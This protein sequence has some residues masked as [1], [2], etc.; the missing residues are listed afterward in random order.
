MHDD[1]KY[2]QRCLQLAA[3][4]IGATYPNPLV[5]SVIVYDGKIIGEGW[6]RKAGQ[7]H[8]EVIA[9]ASVADKA[10]LP[11]ST[12]YVNLEPC[13]HYGKT[14]P[15]ADLIL[16]HRIP[17]VVVG[18]VDPNELVEGKGIQRL[19]DAGI[20]V[21]V[22]VLQSDCL[23]LNRRFFTFHN[24]QRPYIILKWAQSS[25]GF[26]AP[27]SKDARAPVWISN[28]YSRQLVHKWRSEEQ[29]VLAGS[30]T[31]IDDNPRLTLRDWCGNNPIRIVIDRSRR[32][33]PKSYIFDTEA[34][35]LVFSGGPGRNE[36][37][38]SSAGFC[39]GIVSYLFA[40]SITSVIIEG[41][42]Q[43]LQAFIDAGLYDE[44]RVF[45]GA[46]ALVD[47]IPAPIIPGSPIGRQFIE[48]DQLLTYA[49]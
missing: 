2:M 37:M 5:G 34:A 7:A 44:A 39:E 14:P 10:L 22:G 1:Q 46:T 25:D 23:H 9:I 19:R 8:A 17:N 31:V 27:L 38:L 40:N 6:H 35:T 42:R 24:K 20:N 11:Y 15:C 29:A 26:I 30:Q 41:G 47:G 49:V 4:G 18:S 43:V 3:N 36:Q 48:A 33:S 32:I 13:S 12:L 28:I 45:H 21:K 16:E